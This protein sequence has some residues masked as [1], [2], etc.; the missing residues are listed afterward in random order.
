MRFH[1]L[2]LLVLSLLGTA[3][4]AADTSDAGLPPPAKAECGPELGEAQRAVAEGRLDEALVLARKSAEGCPGARLLAARLLA[5]QAQFDEASTFLER[6]LLS[7]APS[8]GAFELLVSLFPRLSPAR[9]EQ[10][11]ALGA[12]R[13]APLHV[14]GLAQANLWLTDI[15]CRERRL[16]KL[17]TKD[18]RGS[19]LG[20][21]GFECPP[22][23]PRQ[24]FFF[25][26]EP[27]SPRR[28]ASGKGAGLAVERVLPELGSRFG[29]HSTQELR[30]AVE[31][32][33]SA[34]RGS[35]WLL[36]WL[37]DYPSQLPLLTQMVRESPDDLD[38]VVNLSNIQILFGDLK[39]ALRTLDAVPLDTVTL[40][41]SR[42]NV[43]GT[44]ALFSMRCRALLQQRKLKEAEA[45]C[46]TALERGSKKNGPETLA[47]VLYL[48]GQDAEALRF[49]RASLA[50]TQ[51]NPAGHF[52]HGLI[53]RSLGKPEEAALAWKAA[54]DYGLTPTVEAQR[55]RSRENWVRAMEA[56]QRK[57]TAEELAF[58]G[59]YY[60]DLEFPERAEVCFARAESLHPGP[61]AAE[62][63]IH[64][65]ESDPVAALRATDAL[66][67]KERNPALLYVMA[68][69]LQ[70]ENQPALALRWLDESLR[71]DPSQPGARELLTR[72]CKQLS[73]PDC[74]EQFR[75]G[76]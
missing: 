27:R 1:S 63:L 32:P 17:D 58:C 25:M 11:V 13:E 44:S 35:V 51:K 2:F 26:T 76:K 67:R 56:Y 52:L 57:Q 37:K 50:D 12:S 74:L 60:L 5:R 62:R 4:L 36:S 22:G 47:L 14:G 23:V 54:A 15:V 68:F 59:H 55:K 65:A 3:A 53:L 43:M 29:I 75:K 69:G 24:V 66:L 42:G 31:G 64:Q 70:R 46:R 28:P 7:P 33:L 34:D 18:V 72:I 41:D 16:D 48:R 20:S 6:E 19:G 45:A 71:G 61:A 38:A 10:V 9:Q 21:Y 30:E 39:G 8:P 49:I 73:Q 40:K